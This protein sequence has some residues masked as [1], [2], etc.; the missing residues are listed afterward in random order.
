MLR[1]ESRR[2]KGFSRDFLLT[3]RESLW[4]G[5]SR[6]CPAG[7]FGFRGAFFHCLTPFLPPAD[8]GLLRRA[9]APPRPADILGRA[10]FY[11]MEMIY[12]A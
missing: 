2:R 1:L 9:V 12:I 8:A 11:A 6:P 4:L 5:N 3:R 7:F 10:S